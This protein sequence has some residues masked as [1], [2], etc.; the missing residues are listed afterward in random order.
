M[1]PAEFNKAL[2]EQMGQFY[3]DP[4]GFVM[5]AFPWGKKGTALEHHPHGPDEWHKTMFAEMAAH[6]LENMQRKDMGL[7]QRPWRS[8]VASGH[9]IGKSACVAWLILWLMSTRIDCRGVVTANTEAQL[10]GKTWPELS[11]WHQLG[12]NKHWFTWTAK[13]F[14]YALYD[15]DRRK[16]YMFEAVTWSDENTEGFAG[17]HNESS[18]VVMVFDEASAIPKK[19]WEVASGALTDG[20]PFWFC[21][22]NPTLPQGPFYDK[23]FGPERTRWFHTNVDSRSVRITNKE[24]LQELVDTYGEDSDY[25]RVRVRGEFPRGTGGNFIP[26]DVVEAGMRA[27]LEPDTGAPLILGVDVA[28]FGSDRSILAW[29]QGKDWRSIPYMTFRQLDTMQLAAQ[30]ADKVELLKPRAVLVDG[31]GVGGGVVD[32]LRQ[33]GF[34]YVYDINAGGRPDQPARFMNKRAEMWGLMRDALEG[35]AILPN[36]QDLKTDLVGPLYDFSPSQQIKL[37]RKE[38]MKRRGLASPDIADAYA[39]TFARR[40]VRAEAGGGRSTFK[41]PIAKGVDYDL[42]A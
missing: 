38:D 34:R 6:V 19:I 18:A 3:A 30:V 28:R 4:L 5:F 12:I 42:F 32:R 8:A 39:L 16:T 37:E 27:T 41:N 24:Y 14:Y 11:K 7:P 2:A 40:F 17:L 10:V 25:V 21:F 26:L 13:Q 9:G 31:V 23:F 36:D 20:E 15:E 29:R 33:L 22:G 35:G 1:T